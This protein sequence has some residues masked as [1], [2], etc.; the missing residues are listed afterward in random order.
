[1]ISDFGGLEPRPLGFD[2]NPALIGSE[3]PY[4]MRR[5]PSSTS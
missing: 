2:E 3:E 1:M 5:I 4:A